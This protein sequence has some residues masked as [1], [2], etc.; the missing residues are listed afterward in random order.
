MKR[1]PICNSRLWC[2]WWEVTFW[3][4]AHWGA[5]KCSGCNK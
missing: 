3:A 2:L 5:K 4:F 1:C